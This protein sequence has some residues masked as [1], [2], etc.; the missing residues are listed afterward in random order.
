MTQYTRTY[1]DRLPVPILA[2]A[3]PAKDYVAFLLTFH[4]DQ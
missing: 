3:L 1:T 4:T 2:V